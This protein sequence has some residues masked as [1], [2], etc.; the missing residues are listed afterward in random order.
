VEPPGQDLPDHRHPSP[1]VSALRLSAAL[2]AAALAVATT[3]HLLVLGALV[4][5]VAMTRWGAAAALLACTA[6][7]VR[8]ESPTLSAVGGA[9]AVLG[10]AIDVGSTGAAAS[11]GLAALA[12][13]LLA[14]PVRTRTWDLLVAAC[15]GVVAGTFVAGPTVP[16]DVAVRVVAAV[17]ATAIAVGASRLPGRHMAAVGAG[18]LAL[19]L[20]ATS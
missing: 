9:Q 12:V 15:L 17:V 11:A 2:A 14:P 3:G 16:T 18:A 8:W 5:L 20:A 19:L 7:L 6:V 13:V 1:Q 4:A 10:P